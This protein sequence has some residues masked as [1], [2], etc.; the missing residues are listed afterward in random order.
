MD[1]VID[2][3]ATDAKPS[4][5]SDA[6]KGILYAKA[7]ERVDAARPIVAADLFDNA[8]YEEEE[9]ESEVDQEPQEEE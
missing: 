9:G 5:V 3:I 4:E 8:G 2:L 7:A 1:N 6:I